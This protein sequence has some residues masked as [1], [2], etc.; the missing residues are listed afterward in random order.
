MLGF[1]MR[2]AKDL[3][4][5]AVTILYNSLVWSLLQYAY[6]VWSP[7]YGVHIYSLEKVQHK[8][9][10][11]VAYKMYIPVGH[12]TY[13]DIMYSINIMSLE[14]TELTVLFKLISGSISCQELLSLFSF[15]ILIKV[16]CSYN[17]LEVPFHNYHCRVSR[18]V[19]SYCNWGHMTL[20]EFHWINSRVIW[21]F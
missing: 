3:S 12:Y 6:V 20:L 9:L 19:N 7:Y 8:F 18:S 4:V 5:K 13:D 17:L 1:L 14:N 11:Y 10:W 2:N 15:K 16:I 21:E